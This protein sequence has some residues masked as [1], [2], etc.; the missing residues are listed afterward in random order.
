MWAAGGITA[1]ASP[2]RL[3]CRIEKVEAEVKRLSTNPVAYSN[4][5][6][7]VAE[8]IDD[9]DDSITRYRRCLL[10]RRCTSIE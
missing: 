2:A 5:S 9:A 4:A 8:R 7:T 6:D 3:G 1:R 10:S